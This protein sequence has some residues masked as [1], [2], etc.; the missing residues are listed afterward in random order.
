M[1]PFSYRITPLVSFPSSRLLLRRSSRRW[2]GSHRFPSN[3]PVLS[4]KKAPRACL[5]NTARQSPNPE[6]DTGI[7]IRHAHPHRTHPHTPPKKRGCTIAHTHVKRFP[8]KNKHPLSHPWPTLGPFS[9][10]VTQT[11]LR[12]REGAI[13]FVR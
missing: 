9:T 7:S 10:G 2:L 3:S 11:K 6:K 1:A 13:R 5:R 4:G 12:G 8:F